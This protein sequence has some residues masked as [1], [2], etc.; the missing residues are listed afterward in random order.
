MRPDRI[1]VGEVRGGE[2]LDML[3]ALNTGH[4]G[5]LCTIHANSA[6]DALV[7]LESLALLAGAGLPL[8]AVRHQIAS[9]VDLVVLVQRQGDGSRRVVEIAGVAE[10]GRGGVAVERLFTGI[11]LTEAIAPHRPPRR[12][13][14]PVWQPAG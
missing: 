14:A 8:T 3:Q 1:V 13:G 2:A 10:P 4:D 9:S 12:P 11:P 6:R 5:S 7:R